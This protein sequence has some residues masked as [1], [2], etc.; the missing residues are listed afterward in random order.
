MRTKNGTAAEAMGDQNFQDG[1]DLCKN[2][3]EQQEFGPK[4]IKILPEG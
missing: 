3:I 2:G 4:L 1:V